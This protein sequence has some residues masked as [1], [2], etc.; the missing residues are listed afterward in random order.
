[1]K[2]LLSQEFWT[3][4][5][6]KLGFIDDYADVIKVFLFTIIGFV[7]AV[8]SVFAEYGWNIELGVFSVAGQG[9]WW[10]IEY[11][12]KI[13]RQ[14]RSI[15]EFIAHLFLAFVCGVFFTQLF[16][17]WQW[18]VGV[19]NITLASFLIGMFYQ[20]FLK[21]L[22][23]IIINMANNSKG[24]NQNGENIFNSTNDGGGSGSD[25]PKGTGG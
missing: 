18:L 9:V 1:M 3:T 14:K 16:V 8:T 24:P 22:I 5:L 21:R 6:A 4:L 11:T 23:V 20:L 7:P 19:K 15:V 17:D 13:K 10:V 25:H 2:N 12:F